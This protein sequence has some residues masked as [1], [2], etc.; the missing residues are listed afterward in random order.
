MPQEDIQNKGNAII[1]ANSLFVVKR[2]RKVVSDN[3][4]IVAFPEENGGL[5]HIYPTFPDLI[6][7]DGG[8]N[9]K[10]L[11]DA[12]AKGTQKHSPG[13]EIFWLINATD[14][15]IANVN[16]THSKGSHPHMHIIRGPLPEN[17]EHGYILKEKTYTPSPRADFKAALQGFMKRHNITQTGENR[18]FCIAILPDDV[19]ESPTHITF[20]APDFT[21]FVDFTERA[22]PFD[23]DALNAMLAGALKTIIPNGGARVICDDFEN[24]G[25]FTLRIQAGDQNHQWFKRPQPS[26]PL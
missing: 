20:F 8:R 6:D 16:N 1:Y 23:Y 14:D 24:A 25:I 18:E 10:T 3:S 9:L 12:A 19:R 22:G 5:N 21:D 11:F 26:P 2:H 13:R 4:Y 7:G 15:R 17:Y